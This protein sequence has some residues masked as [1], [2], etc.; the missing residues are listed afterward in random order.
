MLYPPGSA[1]QLV[2]LCEQLQS[3]RS[4]IDAAWVLWWN[5]YWVSEARVRALF[6]AKAA[7]LEWLRL[8]QEQGDLA[9]AVDKLGHGR[10]PHSVPRTMRRLAGADDF[11]M[12]AK[13]LLRFFLGGFDGF[14]DGAA[15]T[16]ARS[17]GFPD[18]DGLEQQLRATSPAYDPRRLSEALDASSIEDLEAARDD[19]RT[20]LQFSSG[21][22]ALT[23]GEIDRR[24]SQPFTVSLKRPS[25]ETGLYLVLLWLSVRRSPRMREVYEVFLSLVRDV[26]LRILE[27]ADAL[28]SDSTH[29][30][31]DPSSEEPPNE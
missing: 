29:G 4:F 19:V 11:P 17:L 7:Q 6:N 20:A 21:L 12:A 3:K 22:M 24:L 5:G 23:E 30:P 9:P 1:R 31:T 13:S 2:A 10:L 27:P 18:S 15:E 14:T 28:K 16:V 25:L 8:K 26:A